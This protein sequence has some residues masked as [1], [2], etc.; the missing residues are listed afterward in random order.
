M[1]SAIA[2][3]TKTAEETEK[4]INTEVTG[5]TEKNDSYSVCPVVSV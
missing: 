4:S 3:R 1:C 2:I 5:E